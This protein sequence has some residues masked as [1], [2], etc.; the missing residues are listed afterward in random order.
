M[1][2]TMFVTEC[3]KEGEFMDIQWVE[4]LFEVV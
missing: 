3:R 2:S 1:F 4:I